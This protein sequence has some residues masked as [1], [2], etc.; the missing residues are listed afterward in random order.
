MD[1]IPGARPHSVGI[2]FR[3]AFRIWQIDSWQLRNH[4]RNCS[5]SIF[6]AAQY[7]PCF[8]TALRILSIARSIPTYLAHD[9]LTACIDVDVLHG[10]LLLC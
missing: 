10:D 3:S 1:P 7:R 6:A 2:D 4:W 5:R 9:G 8:V